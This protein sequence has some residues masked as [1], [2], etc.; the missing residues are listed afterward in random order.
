MDTQLRKLFH[1]YGDI[2]DNPK[3]RSFIR[4]YRNAAGIDGS[5]LLVNQMNPRIDLCEW[6]SND[7]VDLGRCKRG[8]RPKLPI[9]VNARADVAI[10]CGTREKS[11]IGSGAVLETDNAMAFDACTPGFRRLGSED[12]PLFDAIENDYD[13]ND[14]V[15]QTKGNLAEPEIEC[16][17]IFEGGALAAF[18]SVAPL[19]GSMFVD[20]YSISGIFTVQSFRRQGFAAALLRGILQVYHGKRF[21]YTACP[22]T[23][24]ASV[25]LAQSCGFVAV[26]ETKTIQFI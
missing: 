1:G 24:I 22:A 10:S 19:R 20:C 3:A 17:G 23:N 16:F 18:A 13:V 15:A 14:I 4:A 21:Y 2:Y 25:R 5:L 9:L 6:I 11:I 26:G 8:F 7:D 12:A